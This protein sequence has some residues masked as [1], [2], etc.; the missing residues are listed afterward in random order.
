MPRR[1]VTTTPFIIRK[2]QILRIYLSDKTKSV[3]EIAKE[4]RNWTYTNNT[5]K[6]SLEHIEN[7]VITVLN[8]FK[9]Y[10]K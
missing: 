5:C 3:Q 1:N 7:D 2:E 6:T 9:N 10:T 8:N 4:V